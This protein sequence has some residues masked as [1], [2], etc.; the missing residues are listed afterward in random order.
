M[1]VEILAP[2]MLTSVQDAGRSGARALGVRVGGAAD[3]Y[4]LRVANLLVG[5]DQDT[6]AMEITLSGPSL[7]LHRATTIALCGA[8]IDAH[9]DG[10]ALPGWRPIAC[11]PDA[12]SRSER[13]GAAPA[14]ISRSMGASMFPS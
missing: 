7:R 8:T 3:T 6:A 2:G 13:A 11:P 14:R 12:P 4:S 9:A 1:S 5:N 10:I